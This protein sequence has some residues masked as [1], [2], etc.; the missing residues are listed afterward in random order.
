[1]LLH[2]KATIREGVRFLDCGKVVIS[3]GIAA[4]IG[5]SRRLLRVA[6]A[7]VTSRYS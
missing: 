6:T 7:A 4:G 1:V 5:G 3:A 2:P